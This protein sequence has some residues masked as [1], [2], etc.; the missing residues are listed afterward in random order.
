[1]RLIKLLFKT[2]NIFSFSNTLINPIKTSKIFK[3]IYILIIIFKLVQQRQIY[4]RYSE[5]IL[6][7]NG[8]GSQYVLFPSYKNIC[9][10]KIYISHDQ[11]NYNNINA[12]SGCNKINIPSNTDSK[13]GEV[14]LVWSNKKLTSARNILG[15]LPNLIE[16]DLS[17]FDSSEIMYMDYMFQNDNALKSINFNN[18]ITSSVKSMHGTFYECSNLIELDLSTFDT[19]HVTEMRLMFFGCKKLVSLNIENFDTS[20]VLNMEYLFF[21]VFH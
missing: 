19:S 3:F 4:S 16:V 5:I 17:K 2:Q 13:V 1:M 9:P 21:N 14:K 15:D 20:N 6:T 11:K 10:E 18:F 7:I 8:D 12:V